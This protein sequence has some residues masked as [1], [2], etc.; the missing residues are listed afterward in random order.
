M[1]TWSIETF[2]LAAIV[3]A[4]FFY[5]YLLRKVQHRSRAAQPEAPPAPI[6]FDSPAVLS[7][8]AWG[9]AGTP[10]VPEAVSLESPSMP[11]ATLPS[12]GARSV[13]PA[14]RSP[15]SH[16]RARLRGR[17]SLQEAMVLMT[18][19]GPCRA[20]Q[21]EDSVSGPTTATGLQSLRR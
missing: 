4:F 21:P 19:L 12:P 20:N 3:A 5:N 8:F 2:V 10:V 18:V 6:V 7:D 13:A 17:Q 15:I 1:L 9:S 14:S 16:V 11:K